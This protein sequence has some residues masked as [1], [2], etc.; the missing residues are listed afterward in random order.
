MLLSKLLENISD[1]ETENFIDTEII[2]VESDS[3]SI[4][5]GNLFVAL[6]GRTVDGIDFLDKAIELGC[7]AVICSNESITEKQYPN[8]TT[9]RHKDPLWLLGKLLNKFYPEKPRH[10]LAVTGT[11]G[12]TSIVEIIR[13]ILE[14]LGYNSA[15]IGSLGLNCKGANVK[16]DTLTMHETV[17]VH[18]KLNYLKKE[19]NIDYLAVEATSQGMDQGRLSGVTPEIGAFT[20][21]T[22]DHL[23]YHTTME[24]Y[25]RC[26]MILFE[27]L[28]KKQSPVVLNADIPEFEKISRVCKKQGHKIISYGYNG[29]LKLLKI[30]PGEHSQKI[31]LEYQNKKYEANINLIGEFQIYNLLCALGMILSLNLKESFNQILK[32]AESLKS[33]AEGRMQL[34]GIKNNGAA[35]YIDYA[36][37]PDALTQALKALRKHLKDSNSKGR[38]CVVTGC[39]GDRDP[40]KRPKM[41][42]VA[43]DLADVVI[44]T[45]DNPRSEDPAQ[46]RKEV[47]ATCPKG[48]EIEGRPEAIREA[49]SM[50]EEGDILLLANKGHERYIIDKNGKQPYNEPEIVTECIK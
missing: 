2:G 6:K 23:D 37:S 36:H 38:L 27:E 34:A 19:K 41:G 24:N 17:D 12:K 16:E 44:I 4:Q 1:I 11:N 13:K 22:Q 46:I 33:A 40:S 29:N 18:K 26:K 39:G 30:E 49:I 10:I 35:I 20:N 21:I 5:K 15:S 45:E 25:F 32:T 8:L 47:L 14:T 42:K 28:L 43:N 3:R 50:L 9:I 31:Y 48:I 7:A